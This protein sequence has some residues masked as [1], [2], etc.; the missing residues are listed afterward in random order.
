MLSRGESMDFFSLLKEQET[1]EKFF[2]MIAAAQDKRMDRQ[3]SP[4]PGETFERSTSGDNAGGGRNP[5]SSLTVSVRDRT[6]RPASPM[7]PS[8]ELQVPVAEKKASTKKNKKSGKKAA[9]E[10]PKGPLPLE[11]QMYYV[12]PL[13]RKDAEFRLSYYDSGTFMVRLG[14]Q[15]PVFSV[16]YNPTPGPVF[17]THVKVKQNDEGKYQLCPVECFDTLTDLVDYYMANVEIFRMRFWAES[18][19]AP[20]PLVPYN[21]EAH[22]HEIERDLHPNSPTT[23]NTFTRSA[24]GRASPNPSATLTPPPR[25]R[26]AT[27]S[28]A[29]PP[30]PLTPPPPQ[31][32]ASVRNSPL[33]PVPTASYSYPVGDDPRS[34]QSIERLYEVNPGPMQPSSDQPDWMYV[35]KPSTTDQDLYEVPVSNNPMHIT[36][37]H[38]LERQVSFASVKEAVIDQEGQETVYD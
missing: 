36:L 10:E 9:E 20:P 7:S 31:R 25:Q 21:P 4:A 12:G 35:S 29:P 1:N 2:D 6:F 26:A 15:G 11:Q 27:T 19:E 8:A 28:G 32:G 16:R 5:A 33:P 24:T 22:A 18:P 13:S 38:G 23:V 34:R 30:L 14:D 3:R 37:P 17:C